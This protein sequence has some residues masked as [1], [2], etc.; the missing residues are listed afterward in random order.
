MISIICSYSVFNIRTYVSIIYLFCNRKINQLIIIIFIPFYF[1]I[2]YT[3]L[4]LG[5]PTIDYISDPIISVEGNAT[6]LICSATND[7]DANIP[8]QIQWYKP[9]GGQVKQVDSRFVIN[10]D[11]NIT[12][13]LQSV[14]LIDPITLD[15]DGV[16]KC[17][18]FN[19]P[20]SYAELSTS[21]TVECTSTCS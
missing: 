1:V 18:A 9:N 11:N 8:S 4:L 20:E 16:Y 13:K 2:T 12:G 15:D 7:P 6:S 21:L 17:R 14:L 10:N 19:H 5:Q 3:C